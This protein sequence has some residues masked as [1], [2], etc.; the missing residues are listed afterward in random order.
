MGAERTTHVSS[1]PLTSFTDT[2]ITPEVIFAIV[3]P[4]NVWVVVALAT[5]LPTGTSVSAANQHRCYK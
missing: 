2:D 5:A 3:I 4:I 1:E